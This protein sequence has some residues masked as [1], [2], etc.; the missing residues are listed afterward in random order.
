MPN[1]TRLLRQI[2]LVLMALLTQSAFAQGTPLRIFHVMS[3]D[4]P[5]RWTDGQYAGFKEGLGDVNA[6]YRVFQMDIKR[7][8]SAEQKAERG[9]LAREMIETWKPDLVYLSDDA[10]TEHVAAHYAGSTTPFV[11]SGANKTLEDSGDVGQLSGNLGE[12]RLQVEECIDDLRIEMLPTPL[13]DDAG[14][15]LG[16]HRRLV[17]TRRLMSASNTSASA[18]RRAETGIS[19]PAT[20]AG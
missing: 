12:L 16:I 2:T 3:F 20:P 7:Y 5:W 13:D 4:S 17:Y 9:R 10:A 8:A 15:L 14:D 11:F 19:S 1:L 6:E 18:I